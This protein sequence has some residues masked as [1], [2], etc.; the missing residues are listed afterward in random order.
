MNIKY[1]F[2][3]YFC[4]VAKKIE[5]AESETVPTVSSEPNVPENLDKTEADE[6]AAENSKA[7]ELEL[8]IQDDLKEASILH[9]YQTQLQLNSVLSLQCPWLKTQKRVR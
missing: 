8:E 5:V 7:E 6:P 4:F 3:W 1:T 2:T 9:L